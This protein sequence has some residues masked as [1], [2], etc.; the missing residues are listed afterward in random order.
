[1]VSA[2]FS[3]VN[4]SLCGQRFNRWERLHLER[5]YQQDYRA[6]RTH[7]AGLEHRLNGHNLL[8]K[9]I[10]GVKFADGIVITSQAQTRLIVDKRMRCALLDLLPPCRG[11]S[12]EKRRLLGAAR[13]A[14]CRAHAKTIGCTVIGRSAPACV[15]LSCWPDTPPIKHRSA[16]RV[17]LQPVW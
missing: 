2:V 11:C 13:G 6:Q 3:P 12:S 1:M 15:G 14:H 5:R 10:L 16:Y 8:P 7:R 9:L 17:T 4:R